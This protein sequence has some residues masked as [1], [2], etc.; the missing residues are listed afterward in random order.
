MKPAFF[1]LL[2]LAALGGCVAATID[3]VYAVDEAYQ[4]GEAI[5][6]Y[7][8]VGARIGSFGDEKRREITGT[9]LDAIGDRLGI[10]D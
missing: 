1:L 10:K 8:R 2:L 7:T 9:Y 3:A 5:L 6:E 4:K